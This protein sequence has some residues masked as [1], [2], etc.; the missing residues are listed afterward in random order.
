[1]P[2]PAGP[3]RRQ[4][5]R[6]ATLA[7]IRAAARAAL[8]AEG[9]DA[10]TLRGIATDLGMAPA[11]VHYYFSTRDDLIAAVIVD[12]F[13]DLATV[14]SVAVDGATGASS[15]VAAALAYRRWAL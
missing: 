7:E 13:D 4:Q 5:R 1:M 3:T 2:R 14:T 8:A 11:G 9:P 10:V 15:W 12:A 6:E